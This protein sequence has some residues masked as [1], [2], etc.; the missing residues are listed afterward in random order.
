[1]L[2]LGLGNHKTV[3][4]VLDGPAEA[5]KAKRML[6]NRRIGD[7][8]MMRLQGKDNSQWRL[9]HSKLGESGTGQLM[10]DTI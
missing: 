1:M 10:I 8:F 3:K 9:M 5:F 7:N 6:R 4:T 2:G